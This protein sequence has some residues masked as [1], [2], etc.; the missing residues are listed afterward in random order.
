MIK[1]DIKILFTILF[2]FFSLNIVLA[3]DY[4]ILD[5]IIVTAERDVITLSEINKEISKIKK[6]Q[7]FEKI[8]SFEIKKIRKQIIDSLIEKKLIQQ[9]AER[10]NIISSNEEITLIIN[11][12][13]QNNNITLNDLNNELIK[14]GSTIEEFKENLIHNLTIQKIKD[15]EIMPYVNVS[16]YEID[17]WLKNNKDNSDYEYLISHMLI[18]HDNPQKKIII[19]QIKNIKNINEFKRIVSEFSDGPNAQNGGDLGWNKKENLPLIFSEFIEKAEI[20]QISDKIESS[21]GIH[22]LYLVDSTKSNKKNKIYSR[23]YKFQQILLKNNA[24]T[25]DDDQIKKINNIRNQ[26]QNGLNFSEAVKMYSDE[27][28]NVDENKLNWVN[29][30]D[31]LPDFKNNIT[32]Y[33]ATDLFGPFKTQLGW[34][35]VKVYDYQ[36]ADITKLAE[37]QK[38]RIEIARKKTEIRFKDWIDALIKDSKITYFDDN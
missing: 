23:Q 32:N 3:N 38:A 22:F 17:S 10:L 1:I 15:R 9:Y 31:L 21:N 26:I 37:K 11:N 28:F 12:I 36:K 6:S 27:Q 24:I 8:P 5:R 34:H 18:K 14:D 19:D 4:E 16:E 25:T 33:P 2:Y 29:Y 35:L 13:L 30:D 7:D 20:N